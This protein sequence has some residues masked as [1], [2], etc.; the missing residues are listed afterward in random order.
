MGGRWRLSEPDDD[1]WDGET[2]HPSEW[3]DEQT[4]AMAAFRAKHA[5]TIRRALKLIAPVRR[6][7][8][9]CR[10]DV[11][12]AIIDLQYDRNLA[13]KEFKP[14][15]QA[16]ARLAAA[17]RRVEV[18]AKHKALGIDVHLF[19]PYAEIA[20]WRSDME[21]RA[22][23]KAPIKTARKDADAKRRAVSAA[24][25]LMRYSNVPNADKGRH[26]RKLAALLYG[27][28]SANLVKQCQAARLGQ[29]PKW[30]WK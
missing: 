2:A 27:E 9:A 22:K 17:L 28:P 5:E 23:A 29:S 7:S 25:S 15:K 4:P 19:F 10:Y 3:D 20:K 11:E 30:G 21:K 8:K 26:F 18:V 13:G 12:T 1:A 6:S 16:A 24:L 14:A